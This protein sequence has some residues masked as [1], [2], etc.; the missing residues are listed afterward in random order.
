M[1]FIGGIRCLNELTV[2][3]IVAKDDS[4]LFKN[5]VT[6]KEP[7]TAEAA[8]PL[9]KIIDESTR[10]KDGGLFARIQGDKVPAW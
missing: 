9:L 5:F 2:V 3:E 10:E 6:G 7:T 1:S 4:G 8:I